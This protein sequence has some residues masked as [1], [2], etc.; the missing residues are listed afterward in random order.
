MK[1]LLG[2]TWLFSVNENSRIRPY[3]FHLGLIFRS[4][5]WGSAVSSGGGRRKPYLPP[6]LHEFPINVCFIFPI[7]MSHR[8][9]ESKYVKVS[10][11]IRSLEE[12]GWVM[13]TGKRHLLSREE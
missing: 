13:G 5:G 3:I 6:Y 2:N 12:L 9:A 8:G 1:F 4:Q 11:V 10:Q 7:E